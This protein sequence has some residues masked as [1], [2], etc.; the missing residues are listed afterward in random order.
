MLFVHWQYT[1]LCV[2]T[3][4][5]QCRDPSHFGLPRFPVPV[6]CF[7][8]TNRFATASPRASARSL[9]FAAATS[10]DDKAGSSSV[11]KI[12]GSPYSSS[13][14]CEPEPTRRALLALALFSFA[15]ASSLPVL[16]NS[17]RAATGI[18]AE[19]AASDEP[20]SSTARKA[21]SEVASVP[22]AVPEA[23]PQA[24]AVSHAWIVLGGL[25]WLLRVSRNALR[26]VFC[27]TKL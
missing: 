2:P 13:A 25:G 12:S 9:C 26:S 4:T 14:Y 22:M 7:S 27:V 17:S 20:D 11:D 15:A 1:I 5:N 6:N 3:P 10:I 18:T 8:I 16:P 24:G 21:T 23:V 19:S